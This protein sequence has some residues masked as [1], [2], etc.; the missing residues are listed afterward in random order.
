VAGLAVDLLAGVPVDGVIA[1]QDDGA[2]GGQEVQEEARECAAPF[3]G[4]P[5]WARQQA[6]VVGAVPRR[7]GSEGAKQVGDRAAAGGEDGGE[8]QCDEA[9][10]GRLGE[11]GR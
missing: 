6:L 7:E 3:E 4:R 2:L 1:D 11:R 5:W 9:A 10:V 8:Q